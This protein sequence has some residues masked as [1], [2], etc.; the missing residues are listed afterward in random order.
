M[1]LCPVTPS[2]DVK[3]EFAYRLSSFKNEE[4][5]K[6]GFIENVKSSKSKKMKINNN[7]PTLNTLENLKYTGKF[8]NYHS[9]YKYLFPE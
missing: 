3:S 5:I 9:E 6:D 4:M 8:G 1:L 2:W 7:I